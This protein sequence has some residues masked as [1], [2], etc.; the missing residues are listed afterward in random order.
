MLKLMCRLFAGVAVATMVA[1]GSG[2]RSLNEVDPDVV[3]QKPSFAQV[4][5]IFQRDC[6]PCHTGT[7]GGEE[8]EEDEEDEAGKRNRTLGVEPGLESCAAIINNLEDIVEDVFIDNNMPPGHGR[9]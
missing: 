5:P 3:A 1:C 7:G 9:V 8:D 6:I 2:D 4:C